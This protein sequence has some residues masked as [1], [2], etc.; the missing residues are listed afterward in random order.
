[1]L[2]IAIISFILIIFSIYNIL[3]LNQ[4][5]IKKDILSL[6]KE[7]NDTI[8]QK[9]KLANRKKEPKLIKA[10]K[11]IETA[12]ELTGKIN[13]F[14]L[15]CMLSIIGFIFGILL[16]YF[17][18]NLLILPILSGLLGILP[19]IYVKYT[20]M[21]FNKQVDYELESAL[22][23]ITSSYIRSRDIVGAVNENIENINYPVKN[24]FIS[25]VLDVN[26]F[27][28]SPII[29]IKKL[30]SSVKSPV[31]HEWCD[32]C[33]A[34]QDDNS[35]APS[36]QNIVAKMTDARIIN[37]ELDTITSRPRKEFF[38]VLILSYI[39]IFSLKILNTEWYNVVFYTTLGKISFT[40][41]TLIALINVWR[42][43]KLSQPI[44]FDV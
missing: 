8:I 2:Y 15:I 34:C 10:I 19:Y 11:E 4:N 44:T 40:I 43:I 12:L 18:N 42:V 16:A 33:I 29:A 41:M 30:R 24:M 31:F 28:I 23:V 39:T 17:M 38:I 37:I 32:S 26:K 9:V 1:M 25:F 13:K 6:T 22:S 35:M 20:V 3:N 14:T 27:G 36:L 21:T 5:I 7:P